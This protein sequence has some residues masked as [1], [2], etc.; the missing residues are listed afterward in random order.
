[1]IA[2]VFVCMSLHVFGCETEIVK[3]ADPIVN[4][5]ASRFEVPTAPVTN[6]VELTEEPTAGV[7]ANP[8]PVEPASTQD[9]AADQEPNRTTVLNS[10]TSEAEASQDEFRDAAVAATQAEPRDDAPVAPAQA[11]PEAIDRPHEQA[12]S[13]VTTVAVID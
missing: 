7:S 8:R 12:S 2:V 11:D 13:T 3:A 9:F 10:E 5:A 4:P 6:A 1:M